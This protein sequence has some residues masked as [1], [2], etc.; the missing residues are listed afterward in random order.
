MSIIRHPQAHGASKVTNWMM[1]NYL[2]C[3]CHQY[4]DIWD[5]LLPTA[6]FMY[7]SAVSADLGISAFAAGLGWTPKAPLDL[8]TRVSSPIEIVVDIRTLFFESLADARY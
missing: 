1:E 8:F 4:Q 3:Y 5:Q 2:R 6:G 7:D